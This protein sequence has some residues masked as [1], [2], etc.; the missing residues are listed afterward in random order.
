MIELSSNQI[1]LGNS[2]GTC[3]ICQTMSPLVILECKHN[4]LQQVC[5]IYSLAGLKRCVNECV[6]R[7]ACM[8]E[9]A[10]PDSP[11]ASAGSGYCCRTLG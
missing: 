10:S 7:Q 9:F 4:G 3:P 6:R 1:Y 5:K 11:H 2:E 8:T